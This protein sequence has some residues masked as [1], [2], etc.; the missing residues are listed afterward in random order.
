MIRTAVDCILDIGAEIG[1]GAIWSH[2]EQLLY[3]VDIPAGLLCRFDPESGE[4]RVWEMGRPVGCF[5]SRQSGD[6]V[7]ALTDGFF[8]FDFETE[9]LSPIV[10]TEADIVDNRFNDGSVDARGR[11]L[12]RT[13]PLGGPDRDTGPKGTLYCL[14]AERAVK[15]VMNGFFVINDLAFSPDGM[16]AYVS[17]SA[18]WIQ[19]IWAFDYDL[20]DGAWNNRRVFFDCVGP[21]AVPTVAPSMPTGVTGWPG[22][23]AGNCC[24]SRR[25]EKST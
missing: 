23:P 8:A 5:A 11:L 17:D 6:A 24:V 9:E 22:F 18:S 1:E 10:D 16:T 25:R 21:P 2:R 13:M 19:T 20:D 4:N 14:D 15:T 12:A 3:W 7:V